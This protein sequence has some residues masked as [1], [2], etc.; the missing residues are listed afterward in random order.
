L[1]RGDPGVCR[2]FPGRGRELRFAARDI[3]VCQRILLALPVPAIGVWTCAIEISGRHVG[4]LFGLMTVSAYS[5]RWRR[6]YVG[7]FADWQGGLGY[8]GR[9]QGTRCHCFYVTLL[10]AAFLWLFVTRRGGTHQ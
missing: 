4:A 1:E 7:A 5:E 2:G 3:D 9:E 10:A 6:I 8:T